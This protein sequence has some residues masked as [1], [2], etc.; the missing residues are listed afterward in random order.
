MEAEAL[1]VRLGTN[2]G[3]AGGERIRAFGSDTARWEHQRDT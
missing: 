3:H 2:V 1:I